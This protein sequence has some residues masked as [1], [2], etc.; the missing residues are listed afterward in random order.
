M[1]ST[2]NSPSAGTPRTCARNKA[3]KTAPGP[4]R[5]GSDPKQ[6]REHLAHA[7]LAQIRSKKKSEHLAHSLA[8]LPK[9]KILSQIPSK[10]KRAAGS[11][12][13]GLDTKQKK[14]EHLDRFN[15]AQIH[16]CSLDI[17]C[18][19]FFSRKKESSKNYSTQVQEQ[20]WNF[21]HFF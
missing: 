16:S 3:K 15:L 5:P 12:Q 10:K 9:K 6:K 1:K 19:F 13:P 17:I 18:F 4:L 21:F 7:N 20:A 8:Q 2:R 14:R 11:P